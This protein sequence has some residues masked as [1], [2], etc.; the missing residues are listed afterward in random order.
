MLKEHYSQSIAICI[1]LNGDPNDTCGYT[2]LLEAM[3]M[4][5][6]VLM[7]RS[8]CLD[9]NIEKENI[10]YYVNP[11][12]PLDWMRKINLIFENSEEAKKMGK[13]G[14]KLVE[15]TYNISSYEKRVR[16][17]LTKIICP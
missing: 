4:S 5:K 11:K 6:P 13:N 1:S 14:R 16:D 7:T 12:D 3:S 10:G 8:G 2:E 9:I 17:F 15:K